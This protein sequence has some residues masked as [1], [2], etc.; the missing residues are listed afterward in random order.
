MYPIREAS[1]YVYIACAAGRE[2]FDGRRFSGVAC[3]SRE[4]RPELLQQHGSPW[5]RHQADGCTGTTH[6]SDAPM[7]RSIR[8]AASTE[9]A[10]SRIVASS[11]A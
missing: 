3:Q 11:S 2:W 8:P 5:C 1:G 10:T 6:K 4:E 7:S 9:T